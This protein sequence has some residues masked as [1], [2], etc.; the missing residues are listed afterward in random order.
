MDLVDIALRADSRRVET[1]ERGRMIE[2][3]REQGMDRS[4]ICRRLGL[5]VQQYHRAL[6]EYRDLRYSS[7]VERPPRLHRKRRS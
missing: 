4:A 3:H 6:R 5:N 2:R 1:L 7:A